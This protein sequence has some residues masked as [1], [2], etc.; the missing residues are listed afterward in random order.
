M[1][2]ESEQGIDR[3]KFLQKIGIAG[4]AAAAAGLI[5]AGMSGSAFG[6]PSVNGQVYGNGPWFN[7]HT[8]PA[9]E[10]DWSGLGESAE[11]VAA[12]AAYI[13]FDSV[14]LMK[15]GVVPSGKRARCTR[16][17]YFGRRP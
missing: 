8:H 10:I 5:H 14:E 3:R 4:T 15:N 11:S 16:L 17:L 2:T 9:E 7:P 6:A 13:K 1:I 12:A